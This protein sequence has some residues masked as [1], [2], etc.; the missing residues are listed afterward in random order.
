MADISDVEDSLV[1]AIAAAVY[2]SGAASPSSVAINGA[3]ISVRIFPGWPVPTALDADM[4]AGVVN[5]SVYPQPGMEKNT[6][7]YDRTWYDQT[8]VACSLTA[9]VAGFAVTIGGVVTVGHY[10][11]IQVGNKPFSYAAIAG[12]TLATIATALAALINVS[13]GATATGA[14]ISIVGTAT[15]RIVARLGAPGTSF[16]ELE[17]TNQRFQVTIWASNN[18][19]RKATA[20]IIRPALALLDFLTYADTSVGRIAYE[21]STDIDRS[22]KQNTVCRDIFY[23]VEYPTVQVMA[24]Y[25]ITTFAVPIEGGGPASIIAP[26]PIANFNPAIT[27]IN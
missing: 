6:T 15:G 4:A 18:A 19:Q 25:P 22:A 11:T 3:A 13:F 14:V 10:V 5:I 2:P 9:A 17:R 24:A 26:A 20:K 8:P 1:A 16:L 21:N 7:R 27:V 12:D 23:W